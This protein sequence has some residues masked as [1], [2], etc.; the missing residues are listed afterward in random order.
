V[1]GQLHA[2]APVEKWTEKLSDMLDTSPAWHKFRIYLELKDLK[3]EQALLE[4]WE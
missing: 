3:S 1:S 2:P 4:F